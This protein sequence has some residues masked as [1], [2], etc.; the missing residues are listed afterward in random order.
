MRWIVFLLLT[1]VAAV[2]L[3]VML[4]NDP[5]LVRIYFGERVVEMTLAVF[6]LLCIGTLLGLWLAVTLLIWVWEFPARLRAR[7]ARRRQLRARRALTE[8]LIEIAEGRWREG[9]R[10][11][12][13]NARDSEVPLINYLAA[14]RAAQL[15]EEDERR[16]QHLKAAYESTPQATV[17]VLLTQAELQLAH[18]QYEH[19]LATLRRLQDQNPGHAY[20]L[21]LLARVYES[22][23]EW[24]QIDDLI[25]RLRKTEVVR[26]AEMERIEVRALQEALRN[27]AG[28]EGETLEAIWRNTPRRMRRNQDV[29]RS[30]A[31]ALLKNNA[32]DRAEAVLRDS[33]KSQWND[34]LVLLYADVRSSQPE[35]QLGRVEN[36][37]KEHG[38]SA[39]LLYAAGHLCA[40]NKLWGKARS[41]LETSAR[42]QPNAQTFRRLG[43]LL[44]ELG[45]P[46]AAMQAFRK[47][48]ELCPQSE[49]PSPKKTGQ[50][51]IVPGK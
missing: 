25:P 28:Q 21:K 9:E 20:G 11:L 16:D 48:L 7:L 14:A 38:D 24:R 1:L 39:A 36:W 29:V 26:P 40:T 19:A 8:G 44:Q 50:E 30:Y 2:A 12:V 41:Y 18:G 5:G 23:G 22:L 42:I 45:Q 27:A 34:E 46:E 17:A 47:G 35:K 4:E 13:R 6:A 49:A 32:N 43:Y 51:I 31:L 10:R 37:L 15:L 33:L 3:G